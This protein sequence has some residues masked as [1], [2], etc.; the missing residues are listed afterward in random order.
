M[1]FAPTLRQRLR[2]RADVRHAE[3]N[4]PF[5]HIRD[6]AAFTLDA[7]GA[8]TSWN[9]GCAA[10]FGYSHAEALG[11]HVAR[12]FTDEDQRARI[13][14]LELKT[15][16]ETG[17]ANDDRWLMR[18]DGARFWAVG[19]TF[20]VR[21]RS[22]ITTGFTK[23]LRDMTR[24]KN[25]EDAL[26][27]SEQRYRTL[28]DS[29]EEGFCVIQM[30]FDE[31]GNPTD[32]RFLD[33]NS[34]F[35]QQTGLQ[36]AVGKTV[37][38]LVPAHEQHWFDIHGRVALTRQPA[39][40]QAQANALSRWYEVFAFPFEAPELRKVG[41][42]FT[43][44]TARKRAEEA[45]RTSRELQRRTAEHAL[46]R[47]EIAGTLS[48]STGSLQEMLQSSAESIMRHLPAAFARIWT[49]NF[50][51][52][53]LEL[54]ASAGMYTH[55]NGPHSRVPVGQFKIGRIAEQGTP[56]LTNDVRHD[57]QIS[58]PEWARVE[59][60]VAFAGYPLIADGRVLGVMALFAK[61]PLPDDTLTALSGVADLLAQGMQRK[62]AEDALRQHSAELE[63]RVAERTQSLQKSLGAIEELLYTIAH[64]LRTPNRAMR[65]YAE[66]LQIEYAAQLDSTA[67]DYLNRIMRAADSNDALI[68]DLLTYG[69]LNHVEVPLQ[70]VNSRRV[71][72]DALALV[73]HHVTQRQADV[74]VVGDWPDVIANESLLKEVLVNLLTNALKYV[75]KDRQ[76]KIIAAS[77]VHNGQVVLA[78]EDNGPGIPAASQQQVFKPFVR[79][80]NAIGAEGTGMGLAIVRK[81]MERMNGS[82]AVES[83]PH[84]GSRFSVTLKAA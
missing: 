19:A 61:E 16:A 15:A 56:H 8:I 48:S 24:E 64:D 50:E 42:L 63:Q 12:L 3:K 51:T 41:V 2:R 65:S 58:D 52:K 25:T 20:G 49:L 66:L 53:V 47:A 34:A 5:P 36:D 4:P 45:L 35:E 79:L 81:A 26:R 60:M 78:I 37:R 69:R 21:D 10:V 77:T 23:V 83:N 6:Y 17:S 84:E 33:V 28:F 14:E 74:H 31:R 32:Y 54:Q 75:P 55:L 30:I 62:R 27:L 68:R 38:E 39:R 59:K 7:D 43:D 44:V 70:P 9:P 11:M 67:Q 18:K 57:P 46:L 73:H 76:P 72:E 29:I 1:A 71:I 13:P 82:A 80:E 40:F 22:G